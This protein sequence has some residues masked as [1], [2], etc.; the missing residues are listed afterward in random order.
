[1]SFLIPAKANVKER[2]GWKD[3]MGGNA[4]EMSFPVLKYVQC[5]NPYYGHYG[6]N[7]VQIYIWYI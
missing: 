4:R 6:R 5:S 1:M 2:G 7:M 3:S